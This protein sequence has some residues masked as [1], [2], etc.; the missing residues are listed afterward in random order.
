MVFN[1]LTDPNNVS[2]NASPFNISNSDEIIVDEI[3]VDEINNDTNINSMSANP[4][5][6][7]IVKPAP[8]TLATI[9]KTLTNAITKINSTTSQ[10]L[11]TINNKV[12][13]FKQ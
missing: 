7:K 6:A 4:M 12:T 2:L 5:A 10:S 8:V 11:A 1:P 3:I 9:N 13:T